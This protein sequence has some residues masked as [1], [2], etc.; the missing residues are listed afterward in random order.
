MALPH[1]SPMP[2][3]GALHSDGACLHCGKRYG[4]CKAG[5][6]MGMDGNRDLKARSY[7]TYRLCRL[8]GKRTAAGIAKAH[9]CRSW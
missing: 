2:V 7:G 6:V 3:R 8:R 1:L 9:L 5:V 4:G